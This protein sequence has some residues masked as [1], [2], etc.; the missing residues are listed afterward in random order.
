MNVLF[1]HI[2]AGTALSVYKSADL[3]TQKL[4]NKERKKPPRLDESL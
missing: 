1:G 2:K 4:Q 3:G